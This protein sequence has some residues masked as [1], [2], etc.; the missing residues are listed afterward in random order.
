MQFT[1]IIKRFLNIS[2][3][4]INFREHNRHIQTLINNQICTNEYFKQNLIAIAI[5]LFN[6]IDEMKKNKMLKIFIF[7]HLF[8][9][10]DEIIMKAKKM[11]KNS[12]I[13]ND[14]QS[15][16]QNDTN[17]ENII[18]L[19]NDDLITIIKKINSKHF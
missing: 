2:I 9:I 18:N 3:A 10:F 11:I 6:L 1:N 19:N 7:D 13:E 12:F 15:M 5:V 8:E 17:D 14:E 16:N 4:N